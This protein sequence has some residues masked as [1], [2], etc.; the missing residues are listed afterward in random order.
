MNR[1]RPPR[2]SLLL[3]GAQG[4]KALT[5]L[6]GVTI[7]SRLLTPADFGYVAVAITIVGIGE[8]LRDMG[9]SATAITQPDLTESQRRVLFWANVLLGTILATTAIVLAAPLGELFNSPPLAAAL[10]WLSA[11]FVLNGIGAQYRADLTRA[12]RFSSL[13][14]VDTIVP[15]LGVSSAVALAA[16]GAG[17]WALIAQPLVVAAGNLLMV[18][19]LSRWMPRFPKSIRD[20]WELLRFGMHVSWSQGLS[21]AGNNVDTLALGLFGSA[22]QLGYYNR[23]YQVTVQPLALLKQ[24]AT[25]IALPVLSRNRERLADLA[26]TLLIGQMVVAYTVVPVGLLLAACADPVV[27]LFLGPQWGSAVP[28]VAVL[29]V[30][31][32]VQQIASVSNWLF[33]AANRGKDLSLYSTLSVALKCVLVFSLVWFGPV[34]V[35]AGLL[36]SVVAMTPVAIW[37]STRSTGVPTSPVIFGALRPFVLF[38]IAGLAAWTV[39]TWISFPAWIEVLLGLLVF[40]LSSSPAL[41]IRQY[42]NEIATVVHILTPRRFRA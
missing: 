2:G 7:L 11:V 21:Y 35:A 39:V 12:M 36:A 24:P 34:A 4:S 31:G 28:I 42:R 9:L 30:T 14:I 22:V 40:V 20:S 26:R 32:A 41:M 13:A 16:T 3:L 10:P 27:E 23:A 8:I 15:L 33:L 17:Y 37:W 6:L 19:L 18:T 5:L 29:A 1:P 25:S 38:V